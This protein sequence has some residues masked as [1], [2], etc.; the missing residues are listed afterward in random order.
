MTF[1]IFECANLRIENYL[2]DKQMHLHYLGETEKL[3]VRIPVYMGKRIMQIAEKHSIT[4]TDVVRAAL[5]DLIELE[6]GQGLDE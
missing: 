4:K 6:L 1:G 5:G 2:G 3:Q